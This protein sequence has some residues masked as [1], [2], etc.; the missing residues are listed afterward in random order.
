MHTDISGS[1]DL[2]CA[3]ALVAMRCRSSLTG[4]VS[5]SH[6]CFQRACYNIRE[7]AIYKEDNII[8]S[9]I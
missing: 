8:Y 4:M 1:G 6:V 9:L 5:E 7:E 2:A 3:W